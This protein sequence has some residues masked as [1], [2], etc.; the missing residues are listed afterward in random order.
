MVGAWRVLRTEETSGKPQEGMLKRRQRRLHIHGS[1]RSGVEPYRPQR[2]EHRNRQSITMTKQ[3][4]NG[5]AVHL[6][7]PVNKYQ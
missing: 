4:G 3:I 5:S 1:P 6:N 7:Y 2:Q